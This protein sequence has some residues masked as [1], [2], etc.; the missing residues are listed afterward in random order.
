MAILALA[1]ILDSLGH[2]AVMRAKPVGKMTICP[3]DYGFKSQRQRTRCLRTRAVVG[4]E[5]EARFLW[6][7]LGQH[8]WPAALGT[9][10]S[11]IVDELEES[12][13]CI[14]LAG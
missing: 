13:M 1:G 7:N 9:R 8:Q 3:E 4:A 2:P 11:E 6:F 12:V 14:D 5:I 10:R